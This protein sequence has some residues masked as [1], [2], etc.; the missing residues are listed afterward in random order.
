M[1]LSGEFMGWVAENYETE[2]KNLLRF[3]NDIDKIHDAI[4]KVGE[5]LK[6]KD[7]PHYKFKGYLFITYR[8]L[9][10]AKK[11]PIYYTPETD[12]ETEA[13]EFEQ[14]RR[15]EDITEKVFKFVDVNCDPVEYGLF[16]FYYESGKSFVEI[17]NVTGFSKSWIH[18]KVDTVRR[19]VYAHFKDEFYNNQ[20]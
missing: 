11:R 5:R 1:C 10:Y 15:R 9:V 6:N 16:R 13:V 7:I 20:F 17:S 2:T 8:N 3:H 12:T 14:R 4:V 18:L 19:L